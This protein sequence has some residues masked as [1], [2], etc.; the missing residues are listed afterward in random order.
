M[1]AHARTRRTLEKKK[2][3]IHILRRQ[4]KHVETASERF[5]VR[6]TEMT[7]NVQ[8]YQHPQ[9]NGYEWMAWSTDLATRVTVIVVITYLAY[10]VGI[11]QTP[12][13][14]PYRYIH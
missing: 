12:E 8:A 10:C 9:R 7:R 13:L 6:F 5:H 1:K 2:H 4:L 11:K 3:E 14:D